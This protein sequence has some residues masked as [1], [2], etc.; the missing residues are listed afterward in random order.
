MIGATG[1]V[2]GDG[3]PEFRGDHNDG[4]GP[5]GTHALSKCADEAIQAPKLECEPRG[6]TTVRVPAAG[7]DHRETRAIRARQEA[8]GDSSERGAVLLVATR[9]LACARHAAR[10]KGRC[11]Q[12]LQL[13]VARIE[14]LDAH[15]QVFVG[16][17]HG[18]RRI[19]RDLGPAL[20]RQ[21][22]RGR[23]RNRIL[24]CARQQ[25]HQAVHPAVLQLVGRATAGFQY[26]LAI[27]MRAVT[28]RRRHRM[29]EAG[30]PRTVKLTKRGQCRMQRKGSV[31]LQRGCRFDGKCAT[32]AGIGWLCIGN[33]D[34]QA[35]GR[36]TLNDED[37]APVCGG[38]RKKHRRCAQQRG[39]TQEA[40]SVQAHVYLLKNSGDTS[41]RASAVPPLSARA[42]ALAV[43]SVIAPAR[44]R[45][46]MLRAS[47][48]LPDS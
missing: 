37:E 10:F 41:S 14:L 9:A 18:R 26:V 39:G 6:L 32:L 15:Q 42:I 44:T 23:E 5:G 36:P 47:T 33:D 13:A 11:P 20:Q 43:A 48:P 8:R 21:G 31:Q 7:L 46:A 1:A 4:L 3:T 24:A 22:H 27:E 19:G 30:F 17:R 12:C 29:Q 28:V 38:L 35:I 34:V 2:G 45:G 25:A 40:A 16:L